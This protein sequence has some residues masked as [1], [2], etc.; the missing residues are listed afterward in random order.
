MSGIG[1]SALMVDKSNNV[2]Y[3][4]GKNGSVYIMKDNSVTGVSENT[5]VTDFEL[6]QNYPNPFNPSTTIEFSIPSRQFVSLVVYDVLGQA[7]K[8]LV[9]EELET[10]KYNVTLNANE[11]TSGVYI[12]KL[13]TPSVSLS[14][15]M[16]LQK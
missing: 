14:K 6:S 4:G 1:I 8:T 10:G 7:V 3:A 15:K 12:Y 16:I 2:L 11:L 5:V 13:A 9:N